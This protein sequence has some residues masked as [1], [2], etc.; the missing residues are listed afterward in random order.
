MEIPIFHR[1][2]NVGEE[3]LELHQNGELAYTKQRHGM[4]EPEHETLSVRQ[5][6]D[7]WPDM[8]AAIDQALRDIGAHLN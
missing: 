4:R 5:A 8:V 1:N 6:K 3:W 2:G 7:R